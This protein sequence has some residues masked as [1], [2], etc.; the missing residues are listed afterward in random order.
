VDH[1]HSV[2]PHPHSQA[3]PPITSHSNCQWTPYH[4]WKTLYFLAWGRFMS[5]VSHLAV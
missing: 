4:G 5:L 2:L 1:S 3:Q